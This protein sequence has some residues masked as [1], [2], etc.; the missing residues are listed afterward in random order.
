M[1]HMTYMS[2]YALWES[3]QNVLLEHLKIKRNKDVSWLYGR[4][5]NGP[6]DGLA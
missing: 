4:S 5:M 2:E 6:A 1:V 3:V